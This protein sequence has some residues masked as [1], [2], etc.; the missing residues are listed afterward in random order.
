MSSESLLQI[1]L[2]Y[3]IRITVR[4]PEDLIPAL[5]EELRRIE[6]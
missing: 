1:I 4:N 3:G 2:F 6:R 5:L